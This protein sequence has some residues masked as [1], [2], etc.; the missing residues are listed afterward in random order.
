[1]SKRAI[2][3][4]ALTPCLHAALRSMTLRQAVTMAVQ[5][6]PDVAL[7]RF[8]EETARLAVRVAKDPFMPRVTVGSGL[9]Y[10]NG[11]PMSVEGSAPSIVQARATQY[12]F[13]RQQSF[14]IAQAKEDAR[15]AGF[16][17]AGKREDVAYRTAS[18]YLDAGRAER[19]AGLARKDAES[20]QK[21]LETVHEQV[22]EGRA[23]PL[24]EKQA[25]LAVARARQSAENLDA[26]QQ[27]A[28]TALAIV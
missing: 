20:L 2:L 23:L 9:A 19:A 17:V 6:N 25:A 13:N 8:D 27:E 4:L 18:L 10:S 16:G 24:A 1:M 15:G 5:Q 12:I 11:F 14:V 22:I 21:V 7:A 28:Q 3:I 26:E